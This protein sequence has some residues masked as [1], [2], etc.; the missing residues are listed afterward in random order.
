MTRNGLR[1]LAALCI[2]APLSAALATDRIVLIEDFTATWCGPCVTASSPA[3]NLL[4]NDY[5]DTLIVV[6]NHVSD[7]IYSVAFG[8]SRANFYNVTGIPTVC[9]DGVT[10]VV[11]ANDVTSSYNTYVNRYNTRRADPTD[12]TL[13]L[14]G[15]IVSG[16]TYEFN[17]SVGINPGGTAK[18]MRIY[19]V[20]VL[21]HYPEYADHWR[22]TLRQAAATQDVTLN[23]GESTIVTRQFTFDQTSWGK[24]TDIRIV[25]WAQTPATSWPAEVHQAVKVSWP[26]PPLDPWDLG[27]LNCDGSVNGF[28]AEPFALAILSPVQYAISFPNCDRDLADCNSDGS[29]NGFDIDYFVAILTGG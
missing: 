23:P 11:G 8:E 9:F 26:F 28:D 19:M 3:L 2:L 17:L 7:G 22:N 25:A 16:Q 18:T 6:E 24:K 12:V 13:A 15:T 14:G 21:D 4:I 5:P 27:D 29:V 10:R 20:E 1:S